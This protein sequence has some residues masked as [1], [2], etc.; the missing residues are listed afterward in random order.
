MTDIQAFLIAE[1]L[2][3]TNES[4][5]VAAS[6]QPCSWLGRSSHGNEEFD[7]FFINEYMVKVM[8][9]VEGRL[10]AQNSLF[11]IFCFAMSTSFSELLPY[12]VISNSSK[13][14]Q[15]V[16]RIYFDY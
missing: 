7:Q 2:I 4:V 14:G 8:Q 13:S 10:Y 15:P 11:F 1:S 16:G 12:A 9:F 3:A 6:M 5:S